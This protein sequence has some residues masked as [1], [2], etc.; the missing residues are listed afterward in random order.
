MDWIRTKSP[1]L[2][3]IA[4]LA[5]ACGGSDSTGPSTGSAGPAI[6]FLS[7]RGG[8]SWPSLWVANADGSGAIRIAIQRS[9]YLGHSW[10]PRGD[11]LAFLGG[12]DSASSGIYVANADGTGIRR[13]TNNTWGWEA[14]AS[15]VAWSPDG[16]KIVFVDHATG[17]YVMNADGTGLINLGPAYSSV[18]WPPDRISWSPDGTRIA[19]STRALDSGGWPEIYVV[20]ADGSV[21]TQITHGHRGTDNCCGDLN[22]YPIWSSDG[23]RIAFMHEGYDLT[24]AIYVIHVDGSGEV[25][26]T[27][28]LPVAFYPSWSPDGAQLAFWSGPNG[29]PYQ[30]YLM[31]ADGSG[32]VR[33]T[34]GAS[35]DECRYI[36]WSADGTKL[37][38]CAQGDVYAVGVDGKGVLNLS[39]N[40]AFDGEPDW[41]PRR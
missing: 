38:Y 40:P 15:N 3:G 14:A 19:Y 8:G 26:L 37:A 41:S 24:R 18:T 32:L 28:T 11:R 34:D 31:N 33:L 39:N 7:Y 27:G 30:I 13:L 16:S 6:A 9:Y 5:V 12:N 1:L 20:N 4:L 23:T 21:L 36:S 2:L 35:Y 25:D 10:S 29:G 22:T 17:M